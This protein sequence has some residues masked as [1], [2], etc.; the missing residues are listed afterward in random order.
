[1]LNTIFNVLSQVAGAIG[2]LKGAGVNLGPIGDEVL[3]VIQA[4]A[5]DK[6]NFEGG[7]AVVIGHFSEGGI[8]GT[9]VAVKNGGPA[10]GSLGL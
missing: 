5:A 10:A 7:Q 2:L 4:T 1:M 3:K 8:P 6:A 9:I